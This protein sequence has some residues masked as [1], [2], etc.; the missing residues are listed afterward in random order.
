MFA[1][2]WTGHARGR[3]LAIA[4]SVAAHALFLLFLL[5]RLGAAPGLQ[6]T[7]AINVELT[8]LWPRVRQA[9]DKPKRERTVPESRVRTPPARTTPSPLEARAAEAPG[10]VAPPGVAETLRPTLRGLLGCEP[11]ALVRLS[12]EERQRCR[13]RL[14]AE[15][16]HAAAQPGARLNLDPTG[17]FAVDATPYL[18]RKPHN[19]CKVGAGGDAGPSGQEG[20]AA[21]IKCAWSF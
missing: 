13:E 1:E 9:P 20:A 8:R 6:E 12:P 18:A 4:A 17:R 10:P 3:A 11:S 19:G 7:L 5:W 2:A 15:A 21:G 16:V 14:G